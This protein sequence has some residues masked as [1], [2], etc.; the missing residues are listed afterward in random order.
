MSK[1][2]IKFAKELFAP[3]VIVDTLR[4]QDSREL[5]TD[6]GKA[7]K[8]FLINE[9]GVKGGTDLLLALRPWIDRF[10]LALRKEL[11]GED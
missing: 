2:L 6:T 3:K 11:D 4:N 9:F 1:S 5:G 10:Y 8:K 7:V